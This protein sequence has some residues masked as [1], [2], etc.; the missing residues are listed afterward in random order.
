ML[1]QIQG[2][3]ADFFIS[4]I[5]VC[6]AWATGV[7]TN[8]LRKKTA[9]SEELNKIETARK[10]ANAV[11][12]SIDSIVTELNQ[13]MVKQA[14]EASKDGKLTEIEKANIKRTAM[15]LINTTMSEKSREMLSMLYGD[16]PTWINSQI[17]ASVAKKK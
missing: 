9:Q 6:I 2:L 14:K 1:A 12:D 4:V 10:Y 3:A 5:S 17:E 15:D 11:I 13:T 8:F 7:L 16:I